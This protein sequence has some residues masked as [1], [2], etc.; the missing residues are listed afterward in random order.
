MHCSDSDV[1]ANLI[2]NI[3]ECKSV[4]PSTISSAILI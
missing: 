3:V 4:I 2:D 1:K